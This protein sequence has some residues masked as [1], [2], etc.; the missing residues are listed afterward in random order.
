MQ[1]LPKMFKQK[2]NALQESITDAK[3]KTDAAG[4]ESMKHVR[5]ST[6]VI[7]ANQVC[8][9]L[10]HK[11]MK[12][13]QEN[14]ETSQKEKQELKEELHQAKQTNDETHQKLEEAECYH[15]LNNAKM[16]ADVAMAM[17]N[18][19]ELEKK[20]QQAAS[21]RDTWFEVAQASQNAE[22]SSSSL[23]SPVEEALVEAKKKFE[24]AKDEA[25]F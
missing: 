8:L 25:E 2:A 12:T 5:L 19:E 20:Y 23:Q 7:E 15:T 14:L 21:D 11:S 17:K 13:A 3:V 18:C 4:E 22:D 1:G 10:S 9:Q 6:E 24:A 16:S